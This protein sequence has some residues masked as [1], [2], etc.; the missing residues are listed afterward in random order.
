MINEYNALREEIIFLMKKISLHSQIMFVLVSTLF[1]LMYGKDPIISIFIYIIVIA[2]QHDVNTCT[3]CILKTGMYIFVFIEENKNEY[4]WESALLYNDIKQKKP[5]KTPCTKYVLIAS[6]TF[7]YSIFNLRLYEGETFIQTCIYS[8]FN[9][10]TFIYTEIFFYILFYIFVVII[11]YTRRID[12]L[13][14]KEN[15]IRIWSEAKR[16]L[17]PYIAC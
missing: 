4:S 2:F 1:T 5:F 13:K 8:I 17:R 6:V 14:E 7:L 10:D 16:H 11:I 3:K 9:S 12:Y 15:F